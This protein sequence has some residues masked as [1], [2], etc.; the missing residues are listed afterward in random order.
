MRGQ[1]S[2]KCDKRD[3][4]SEAKWYRFTDAAGT[5]MPTS[6]V[7]VNY[8]GTHATGWLNGQH[9]MKEDGAVSRQVCFHWSGNVCRWSIYIHVRNCGSFY[10]Y[11]LGRTPGCSFRYCGNNGHGTLPILFTWSVKYHSINIHLGGFRKVAS[12]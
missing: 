11:H 4:P 1:L 7:Q 2:P 10:V 8:C 6:P 3:F 9:P 5:R 12:T